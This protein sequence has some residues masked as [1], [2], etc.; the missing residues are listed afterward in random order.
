MKRRVYMLLA[1]AAAAVMLTTACQATPEKAVVVGKGGNLLEE[2]AAKEEGTG[3]PEA[4]AKY[5][6][7]FEGKA[8]SAYGER[9]LKI[10]Y[11]AVVETPDAAEIAVKTVVPTKLNETEIKKAIEKFSQGKQVSYAKPFEVTTKKDLQREID[12]DKKYLEGMKQADPDEYADSVKEYTELFKK[13]YE[14]MKSLPD[15]YDYQEWNGELTDELDLEWDLG[16]IDLASAK[17][18]NT[19]GGMDNWFSYD[20]GIDI[21]DPP[22][23]EQTQANGKTMTPDE[24]KIAAQ[25]LLNELGVENVG[26]SVMVNHAECDGNDYVQFNNVPDEELPSHYCLYYVPLINGTELTYTQWKPTAS[27]M[28]GYGGS[29]DGE[30]IRICLDENGVQQYGHTNPMEVKDEV[31][32]N[33]KLLSFEEAIEYFQ[34]NIQRSDR[35]EDLEYLEGYELN[36]DRITLG[37]AKVKRQNSN[38]YLL[39]PVWDFFGNCTEFF[40]Q[41]GGA[42]YDA[43]Q[44]KDDKI[45]ERSAYAHSYMA[46]NAIDGSV[47][48]RVLGY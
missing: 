6:N 21:I 17:I 48:S 1:I 16:N 8:A 41:G 3:V 36:I 12:N 27:E 24:A 7:E 11:D 13:R 40:E 25:E 42:K 30:Y 37:Y 14:E 38:E 9:Y 47:I 32:A 10:N 26:L 22:V 29:W 46:I 28:E 33:A 35:L 5:Q 31:A 44:V 4:P 19:A 45:V 18:V 2:R 15:D 39:V 23:P 43:N 34:D 20:N